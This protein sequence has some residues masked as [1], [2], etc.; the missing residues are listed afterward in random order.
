MVPLVQLAHG[1]HVAD[2]QQLSKGW[3]GG[4]EGCRCGTNHLEGQA[5]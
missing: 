2:L 5:G 3:H 1:E 4:K